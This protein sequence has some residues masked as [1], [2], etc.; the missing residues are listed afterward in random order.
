[1]LYLGSDQAEV[2]SGTLSG[3]KVSSSD[4]VSSTMGRGEMGR[5]G[6]MEALNPDLFIMCI[7]PLLLSLRCPVSAGN[8]VCF[9]SL[10]DPQ[11]PEQCSMG[12]TFVK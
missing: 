2:T 3:V 1:M 9:A 6:D 4:F 8:S 10:I 5:V 12:P 7:A 11:H